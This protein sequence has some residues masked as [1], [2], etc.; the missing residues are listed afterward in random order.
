MAARYFVTVFN[1]NS[2]TGKFKS[3]TVGF[4]DSS[5]EALAVVEDSN[6]LIDSNNYQWLVIERVLPGFGTVNKDTTGNYP[7]MWYHLYQGTWVACGIPQFADGIECFCMH[8]NI[9]G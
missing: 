1:L 4:S 8:H 6:E 5:S 3:R 7:D 2:E 9:K